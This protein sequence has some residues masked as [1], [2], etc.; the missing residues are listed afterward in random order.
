MEI[1]P[2]QATSQYDHSRL[3]ND[4]PFITNH[5]ILEPIEKSKADFKNN[6]L[7]MFRKQYAKEKKENGVIWA[8]VL[9]SLAEAG[10]F[11]HFIYKK[12]KQF[13]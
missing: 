11:L 2:I 13:F 7:I 3:V 4:P 12:A 5:P 9:V 8:L 10:Y 1:V 6:E